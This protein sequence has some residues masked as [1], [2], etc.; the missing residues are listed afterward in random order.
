MSRF[1]TPGRIALLELLVLYSSGA[2][3]QTATKPVLSFVISHV[4]ATVPTSLPSESPLSI[5]VFE[6]ALSS[7]PSL[8]P[9]R[10]LFDD[11]L[12]QL[13]ALHSFDHMYTRVECLD[14]I[15]SNESRGTPGTG[16]GKG[17]ARFARTSPVGQFVRRYAIEFKRLQFSD[18]L[19]LWQAFV[20][21]RHPQAERW[22]MRNPEAARSGRPEEPQLVGEGTAYH[23]TSNSSDLSQDMKVLVSI[24][25]VERLLECQVEWLQKSG[26]RLDEP[27]HTKLQEMVKEIATTPSLAYF[28]SFFEHWRSGAYTSAIDSLHRYFDYTIQYSTGAKGYYQYALLHLAILHADFG[29]FDE[30]V[31]AMGECIA[32]ARENQDTSCLN[33]ALS[34]LLHLRRA[35]PEISRLHRGGELSSLVGGESDGLAFLLH[36]ARE[37]KLWNLLSGTLLSEATCEVMQFPDILQDSYAAEAPV[38]ER[39]RALCRTAYAMAY[40]GRY[41]EALRLLEE[42]NL[43]VKRTLKLTHQLMA[44][45]GVVKLKREIHRCN[46][47]AATHTMHQLRP[48]LDFGEP[49]IVFE[50]QLLELR[51][52]VRRSELSVAFEKVE[53][54]LDRNKTSEGSD[55]NHTLTLLV[56]KASVFAAAGVPVKGFS[57]ALR[58]A[59]TAHKAHNMPC[60]FEALK[61]L[62]DILV[63]LGEYSAV[64]DL[65]EGILPMA[66]ESED[67]YLIG[68]LY[69]L[70]AEGHNGQG[71]DSY[72]L[73]SKER[74][75][76]INVVT[77]Y[78][79]KAKEAFLQIED[80]RGCQ[81]VLT[82][83]A[84][85]FRFRGEEVQAQETGDMSDSLRRNW[86]R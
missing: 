52:L 7:L 32:T 42:T 11:F 65:L 83:K 84:L 12:I 56:V 27:I 10:S 61:A 63:D 55:L 78:L 15:L 66:L 67:Q 43:P 3:P 23:G 79:D 77:G 49:D 29:C 85:I 72:A 47:A 4:V 40:K 14:S 82:K 9:G 60:L 30:A 86:T 74:A 51:L 73:D 68:S 8:H 34:W 53:S 35:H 45:M 81:E 13:F 21:L 41:D 31:E 69:A 70:L 76:N 75:Q 36:K 16:L 58:A 22:K 71:N 46:F 54:L 62:C 48:F 37:G 57:I 17:K 5:E 24:N 18:A 44:F 39:L 80:L 20:A 59:S 28:I 33:F 19:I 1:L 2:V 50:I 38:E 64:V 6:S 26:V 25:E